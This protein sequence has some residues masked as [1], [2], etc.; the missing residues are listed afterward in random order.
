[1][2][3]SEAS[4]H[5]SLHA[6]PAATNCNKLQIKSWPVWGRSPPDLFMQAYHASKPRTRLEDRMVRHQP[7][8]HEVETQEAFQGGKSSGWLPQ[9]DLQ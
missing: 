6:A 2:K 8:F 9:Q 4:L 5:F 1:M 3:G 7:K